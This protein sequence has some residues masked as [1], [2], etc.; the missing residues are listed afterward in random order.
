MGARR[1]T[2]QEDLNVMIINQEP[3]SEHVETIN[4][5]HGCCENR[6]SSQ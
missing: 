5:T 2:L 1:G 3:G 6:G 4:Q